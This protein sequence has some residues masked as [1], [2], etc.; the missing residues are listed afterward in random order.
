[1]RDCKSPSTDLELVNFL[2]CSHVS[3]WESVNEHVFQND[4]RYQKVKTKDALG[5]HERDR[6]NMSPL[7]WLKGENAGIER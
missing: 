5:G 2:H 3:K 4:N 1:M 7:R 6:L